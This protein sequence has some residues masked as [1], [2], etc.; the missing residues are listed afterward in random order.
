MMPIVTNVG[1]VYMTEPL[2]HILG[3]IDEK[4]GLPMWEFWEYE[5]GEE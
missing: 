1:G 5:R 3:E 2:I 4:T